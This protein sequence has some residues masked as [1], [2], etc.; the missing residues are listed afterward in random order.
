MSITKV[1]I[2]PAAK[3]D[4]RDARDYYADK[5]ESTANSFRDELIWSFDLLARFPESTAIAFGQTRLK[6]MRQFPYVVGYIYHD[7]NVHV[8]GVQFGGLG[9]EALYATTV[10]GILHLS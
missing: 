5:G 10:L 3:Q 1:I 7:G 8:T 4:I 9:W 6:P 2:E